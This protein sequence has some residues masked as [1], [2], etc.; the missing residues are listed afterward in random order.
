VS[1][2]LMALE[3]EDVV[4]LA[5]SAIGLRLDGKPAAATVARRKRAMFCNVLDK[6]P[7]A[8]GVSL[9]LNAGVPAP[10]V[11]AK[12][13][14]VGISLLPVAAFGHTGDHIV[15]DLHHDGHAELF[16][17]EQG[18]FAAVLQA[19]EARQLVSADAFGAGSCHQH[20]VDAAEQCWGRRAV[21]RQRGRRIWRHGGGNH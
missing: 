1:V 15:H 6:R 8:C 14:L 7:T 19:E 3:D 10:T 13:D 18:Q 4:E 5:L 17:A 11:A 20:A 2:P 21:S 12:H 9:Q 16:L